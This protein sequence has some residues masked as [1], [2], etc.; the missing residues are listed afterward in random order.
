MLAWHTVLASDSARLNTTGAAVDPATKRFAA[1][2]AA[3]SRTAAAALS[4]PLVLL[5]RGYFHPSPRFFK[6]PLAL[7]QSSE[8]TSYSTSP[9]SAPAQY[10]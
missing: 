4:G 7:S 8:L 1:M 9:S 2:T 3:V 6:V 10:K 5:A